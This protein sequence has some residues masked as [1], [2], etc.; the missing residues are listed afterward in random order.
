MQVSKVNIKTGIN[1][2]FKCTGVKAS[3]EIIRM[4]GV[5][6]TKIT[7]DSLGIHAKGKK[8]QKKKTATR[9]RDTKTVIQ[10]TVFPNDSHRWDRMKKKKIT[11]SMNIFR[12]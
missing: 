2:E 10:S 12:A 11:V 9:K 4:T 3:E 5:D 6:G 8:K 1:C 7:S